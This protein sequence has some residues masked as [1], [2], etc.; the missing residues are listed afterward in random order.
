MNDSNNYLN[1]SENISMLYNFHDVDILLNHEINDTYLLKKFIGLC[2]RKGERKIA[3]NNVSK[4]FLLI[5]KFFS[6]NAIFF[7]KLAVAKLEPFI[8]LAKIPRGNKEIIFPRILPK[9]IR[10]HNAMRIITTYAFK[11]QYN[12]RNFYLALANSIIFHSL[13]GD[14]YV[15]K[16]KEITEIAVMNKRNVKYL[17]KN[18]IMTKIRRRE[19]FKLFKNIKTWK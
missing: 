2:I 9:K 5:K 6:I 7:I 13:P 18:K 19:R 4:A 16:K 3:F 14:F 1:N 8:F 15:K 11:T 12:Y 17:K 10:L